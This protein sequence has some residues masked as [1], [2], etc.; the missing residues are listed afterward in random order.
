MTYVALI[1]ALL[2]GAL[3][4]VLWYHMKCSMMERQALE[5]RLMAI[6]H[7]VALTHVDALRDTA[8]GVVNYVGEEPYS[9]KTGLN[10]ADSSS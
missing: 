1:E 9:A 7:P 3:I 4:A 5:D 8:P 2:V 6:C 10:H